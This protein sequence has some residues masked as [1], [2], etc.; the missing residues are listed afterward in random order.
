MAR[1]ICGSYH[2]KTAAMDSIVEAV[3]KLDIVD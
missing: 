3:S 1:D 2:T